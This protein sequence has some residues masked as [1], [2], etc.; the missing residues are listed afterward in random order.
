[1]PAAT[2]AGGKLAGVS[3]VND[4]EAKRSP[5]ASSR[6]RLVLSV[7]TL[8]ALFSIATSPSADADPAA[9]VKIGFI[10]TMSGTGGVLGQHQYDGFMLGLKESG[11][12]LGGRPVQVILQ[13]DQLKSDV[14]LQAFQKLQENDKVDIVVG[15]SFSNVLL[16]AYKPAVDSKT[17]IISTNAG[18]ALIAGKDCSKYFF[19]TSW[20]NDEQ[21]EAMGQYVEQQHYKNVYLLAPNYPAG[22]EALTGFKLKYKGAVAGE[23]YTALNQLDF[24][25]TITQARASNADA[26][27]AFYPGGFG[28]NFIKQYAQAGLKGTLPLITSSTVDG[29][30]LPA[31]GDAALGISG[32]AP[33]GTD[34]DN[35]ANRA[36]VSAFES[37]YHY[38]P[39]TYAAYSYD[40][41]RLL[42][43][44]FK[45]AG[46]NGDK[47]ALIAAMARA[48]FDSVRGRFSFGNNHYPIEDFYRTEVVKDAQ[49]KPMI[50]TREVV[51]P[52]LHDPYGDA[53]KAS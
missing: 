42:D 16:A 38:T 7:S 47:D 8:A 51:L 30:T 27:F 15:F 37:T 44:A 46:P 3:F 40:A 31:I 28:I 48:P 33:W 4:V 34:L 22:K 1:M 9:A 39:S 18:P 11:N 32:G 20:Q 24:A 10:A 17:I 52:Q 6:L 45:A 25:P 29:T 53:C 23:L 14:G 49:G 43:G 41:A 35:P 5:P 50:A 13:D 19:S 36:F 12:T 21:D 26:V 2:V